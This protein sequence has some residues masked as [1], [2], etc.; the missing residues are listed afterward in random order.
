MGSIN[1]RCE[2][3]WK[4]I[5]KQ[6]GCCVMQISHIGNYSIF[7]V[8]NAMIAYTK[9]QQLTPTYFPISSHLY[10][11]WISRKFKTSDQCVD[12]FSHL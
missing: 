8:S 12:L 3:V 9:E 11:K 5:W 1:L 7:S 4:I 2:S 10:Y 6:K